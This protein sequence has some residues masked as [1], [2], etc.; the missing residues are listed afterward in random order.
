MNTSI[1]LRSAIEGDENLILDFIKGLAD[2]E[3]MSADVVATTEV[4]RENL[5][6]KKGAEVVI[7]E[8]TEV[9]GTLKNAGFALYFSNFSTFLGKPG[10]YLEDLFVYPE[11]RGKGIGVAL[12]KYLINLAKERDYGRMEWSCLDWNEPSIDFYKSFGAIPMSDWTTYRLTE[13][14][15]KMH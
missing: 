11:F 2:Y 12:F 3:K 15:L 9:D 7:A 1:H 10:L 6:V 13:E 4:L 14:I 5:F 8:Y